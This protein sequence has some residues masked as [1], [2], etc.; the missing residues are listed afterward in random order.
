MAKRL[1]CREY[2]YKVVHA[3]TERSCSLIPSSRYSLVYG[4]GMRV[5]AVKGTLG[6][7][8]F[9]TRRHA[10]DFIS[11]NDSQGYITG[12][13]KP[14]WVIKRVV[15]IGRGHT[16]KW[17][18]KHTDTRGIS[19]FYKPMDKQTHSIGAYGTI[20]PNGTMCY[21]AVYVLD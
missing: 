7:M 10:V 6:V 9:K 14:N 12:E 4:K 20:P 16:P 18:S 19:N 11:E 13:Y 8:V 2:R 21:P 1:K 15:T 3:N 5:D 17:I